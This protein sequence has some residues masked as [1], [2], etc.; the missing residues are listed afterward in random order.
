MLKSVDG[1]TRLL[2]FA[3]R[4]LIKPSTVPSALLN[5]FHLDHEGKNSNIL[6][7]GFLNDHSEPLGE[8]SHTIGYDSSVALLLSFFPPLK[9]VSIV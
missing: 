8:F 5:D 3:K 9:K 2:Q 4:F 7:G 1:P 6:N